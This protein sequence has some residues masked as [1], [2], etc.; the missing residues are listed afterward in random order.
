M[1]YGKIIDFHTHVLH[2]VDHG[3][4][5][6]EVS[7]KQVNMFLERGV[8]NIV[9]TSH[10]YPNKD[11]LNLFFKVRNRAYSELKRAMDEQEMELNIRLGAEVLLCAGLDKLP[12][13][14]KL[15]IQGTNAILLELPF[16]D[17]RSEYLHT[18]ENLIDM[19]YRVILA[20]VDRYPPEIIEMLSYLNLKFQI[21]ADSI[22]VIIK[23]P[24]L[25]EWIRR[26]KVVG[27]GSDIHML[28]SS[29]I[30]KLLKCSKKLKNDFDSIMDKSAEI[31]NL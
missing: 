31:L 16:T 3:S 23:K 28:N 11:D 17:F 22:A 6:I 18:L 2:G 27:L 9:S 29:A 5:S 10:Y 21:N 19:G 4:N 14:D 12:G 7:L 26:G 1:N 24:H 15:C 13:L 25:Y 20:H 30:D 8:K